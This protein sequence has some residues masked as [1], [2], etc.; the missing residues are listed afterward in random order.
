MRP[1]WDIGTVQFEHVDPAGRQKSSTS[2][3]CH[4]GLPWHQHINA[5]SDETEAIVNG[6]VM[7]LA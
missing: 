1:Q 5:A 2:D 6:T 7:S 4:A 3:D